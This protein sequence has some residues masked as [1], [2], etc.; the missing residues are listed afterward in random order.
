MSTPPVSG[1]QGARISA[2]HEGLEFVAGAARITVETDKGKFPAYLINSEDPTTVEQLKAGGHQEYT[3]GGQSVYM[4][5]YHHRRAFP[6]ARGY[7]HAKKSP[8]ESHERRSATGDFVRQPNRGLDAVV[9]GGKKAEPARASV[10]RFEPMV[11]RAGE[12]DVPVDS[13]MTPKQ[14]AQFEAYRAALGEAGKILNPPQP[15]RPK[16]YGK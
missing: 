1:D 10:I 6:D 12:K 14:R 4:L 11:F 7:V 9:G 16:T 2:S 13:K 5:P 8:T 15:P 3:I